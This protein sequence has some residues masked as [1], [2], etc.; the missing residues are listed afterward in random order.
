MDA[1]GLEEIGT[2][3]GAGSRMQVDGVGNGL[4]NDFGD[5][6]HR[7]QWAPSASIESR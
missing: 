4:A 7:G 5:L 3:S 2:G 6:R 1:V